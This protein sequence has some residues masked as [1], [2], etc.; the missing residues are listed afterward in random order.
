MIATVRERLKLASSPQDRHNTRSNCEVQNHLYQGISFFTVL[1]LD[2]RSIK[3][4][5]RSAL[6]EDQ[7]VIGYNQTFFP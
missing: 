3:N 6:R 7:S 4:D 2:L 1:K 5:S